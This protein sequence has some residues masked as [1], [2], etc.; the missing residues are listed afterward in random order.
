[1]L[2]KIPDINYHGSYINLDCIQSINP[3]YGEHVVPIKGWPDDVPPLTEKNKEIWIYTITLKSGQQ[4]CLEIEDFKNFEKV[5]IKKGLIVS[6]EG[7][8]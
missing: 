4:F 8:N 6:D 1:M 5:L 2:Y 3:E 7:E